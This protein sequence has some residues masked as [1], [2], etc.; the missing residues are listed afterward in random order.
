MIQLLEKHGAKR[1]ASEVLFKSAIEEQK[2]MK[3]K[4]TPFIKA[5]DASSAMAQ[6]MNALRERGE[7]LQQLEGKTSQLHN[8]A[9]SYA[10]LAKQMKEKNKK[11]AQSCG[12][13]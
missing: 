1:N 13:R 7:R 11:K 9:S 5:K 10:E 8:D 4:S 2:K 6:G 3:N 12:I